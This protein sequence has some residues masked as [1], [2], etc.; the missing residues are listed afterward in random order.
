MNWE[1]GR[2]FFLYTIPLLRPDEVM[3]MSPKVSL[4]MRSGVSP[5]KAEQFI[6]Y[7]EKSMKRLLMTKSDVPIVKVGMIGFDHD[8]HR[9][10]SNGAPGKDEDMKAATEVERHY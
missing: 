5:V 2:L 8:K 6:W 7:K 1:I 9:S 4:V 3:K 10:N